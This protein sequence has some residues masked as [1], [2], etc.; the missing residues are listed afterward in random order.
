MAIST[1]AGTFQT[2]TGAI[3]TTIDITPSGCTISGTSVIF[4]FYNGRTESTD[5][6]G[7]A[8]YFRGAG[9]AV[10][11][12][13][14]RACCSQ[15]VDANAAHD[16]GSRYTDA[17]CIVSVVLES[18]EDGRIDFDSWLSNGARL[19]VDDVMPASRT[20]GYWLITG[21]TNANI[22]EF[23]DQ[24][25]TGN[26]DIT[27]LSFQPDV[28][29]FISPGH[30]GAAPHSRNGASKMGIGFAIS[31][32]K[33]AVWSG[34]EDEGS[35][36]AD[37]DSYGIYGVEV[38]A[39]HSASAGTTVNSR[40]GF[41]SWLSNG[42]R[43]NQIEVPSTAEYNF[44]VAMQGGSWTVE[45]ILTRTDG[46]DIN[47]PSLGFT[48]AGVLAISAFKAEHTQDVPTV[49]QTM[50]IG[51]AHGTA[52]RWAIA[53]TDIDGAADTAISTGIEFD[54]IYLAI[55]T[56]HALEG[57]MDVKTWADPITFV[58]DDT[59]PSAKWVGLLIGGNA[60][61]GGRTTKNTDPFP[62]GVFP[63]VS[64]RVANTP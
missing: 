17:G 42:L 10:S 61:V 16:G 9:A 41:V 57:L 45:E 48:P 34:V 31:S 59:D 15:G 52:N 39:N 1:F 8:S 36:T 35:A 62:L 32:T 12:T 63:G 49:H 26:F 37:T 47:T 44:V 24:A 2:G 18:T 60:A 58:M 27:S 4:F 29:V 22:V 46:N 51:A 21:L 30:D 64:R 6:L 7:R 53:L 28:G 54:E 13:I 11:S 25:G 23:I 55:S 38:V 20:V 40:I 43:L 14:R 3:G 33:Q 56:G 5:T 19:I 50:S